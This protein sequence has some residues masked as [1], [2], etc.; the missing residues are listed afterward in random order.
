M[1]IAVSDIKHALLFSA[2]LTKDP[3]LEL[4]IRANNFVVVVNPTDKELSMTPSDELASFG[5]GN[6][7]MVKKDEEQP[8]QSYQ[9]CLKTEEDL[10]VVN[11]VVTTVGRAVIAQRK[12][13]P[14]AQVR[15]HKCNVDDTNPEKMT[16]EQ[17]HRVVFVCGEAPTETSKA[18][19]ASKLTVEKWAQAKSGRILWH[20]KWGQTGLSPVK[21]AVF[22]V[23][24]FKLKKDECLIVHGSMS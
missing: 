6:F 8:A 4:Q 21:P 2:K 13:K 5:K 17:T 14:D 10:V 9:F 18:N 1:I 24:N 22:P 11:G 19:I 15:Y 7:K 16:F 23:G 20:C 3:S 12:Q